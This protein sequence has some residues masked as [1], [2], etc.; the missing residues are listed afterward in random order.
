M[1]TLFFTKGPVCSWADAKT[2]DTKAFGRWHGEMLKRGIYWPPSQFEAAF[3]SAA[4]T[5][6]DID[7]TVAAAEAAL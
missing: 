1:V 5:E 3:V 6:K 4:H 2:C 7:T